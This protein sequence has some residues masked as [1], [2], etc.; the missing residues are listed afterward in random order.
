MPHDLEIIFSP[1]SG[2]FTRNG[3]TVLVEIYRLSDGWDW[4][5]EVMFSGNKTTLWTQQ[6]PTDQAAFKSFMGVVE[7]EGLQMFAKGAK[8]TLH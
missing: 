5:L 2:E 4:A 1:L 7:T 8:F 3:I 6:F